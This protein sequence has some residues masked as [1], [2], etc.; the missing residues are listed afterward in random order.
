M[1]PMS[2]ILT[3]SLLLTVALSAAGCLLTPESIGETLPTGDAQGASTTTGESITTG[4]DITTGEGVTTGVAEGAYG[5]SC[6]VLGFPP[7]LNHAAISVQPACDGG[8][9]LTI[10]AG[11]CETDLECETDVGE[12]S[13][14]GE[15]GTCTATPALIAE[16]SRCT[17]SCETV[18]DCPAIP[19]CATGSTCSTVVVSGELCC[20]KVC[21]CNDHAFLPGIMSLQELCDE[22]SD[23]CG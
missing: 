17:R 21:L 11:A 20:E 10:I 4:D 7:V 23:L 1:R 18:A 19:G 9:C 5:S 6:Q 2:R 16:H 22:Q 3:R 12:G 8:I 13:V 15:D 14:C